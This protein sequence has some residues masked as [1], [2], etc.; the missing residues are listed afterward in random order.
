MD[1]GGNNPFRSLH[2]DVLDA[3]P[4]DEAG[5]AKLIAELRDRAKSSIG[6]K[7]YPA[8]DA[9]YSKA[10]EV[11]PDATLYAN[12]SM[13]RL[14]MGKAD[15]A[16]ADADKAVE[17]DAG[18]SKAFYR[19]GQS[20]DRLKRFAEAVD[21]YEAGAAL[22]PENK[23][24]KTLA[25]KAQSA[26]EAQAAEPPPLKDDKPA[27][28]K[29]PVVVPKG[30]E[31]PKEKAAEGSKGG[32]MRGY[33][34][35]ADGRKTTFF[36]NDLDDEAKALIGDIAPKP[37]TAEADVGL[38]PM[39][40]GASSWNTAGTW[41]ERSLTP[42]GKERLTNLLLEASFDL[43]GG[44]GTVRVTKVSNLSGD[45]AVT[46]M[47]LKTKHLF[48]WAFTLAWEVDLQD[49]GPCSGTLT[50]PDVTPDEDGEFE[51][52]F[53]VDAS[54]PPSARSVLDAYVRPSGTGLQPAVA[55]KIRTFVEEFNAM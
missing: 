40:A 16:L 42:W 37:I 15:E 34:V 43:P 8:A 28:L 29:M 47:R 51:T 44:L 36:N 2:R 6:Q 5:K 55:A 30:W 53:E 41:E 39:V 21:A 54:T 48:D 20:L 14:A 31:K 17:S 25:A 35:T 24:F 9:L 1:G 26:A 12:R 19:K 22:E 52:K 10:I 49:A 11:S 45:C 27:P 23:T 13:V 3:S 38:K 7:I 4:S 18:Y 32:E 46:T 50:Y 33:K